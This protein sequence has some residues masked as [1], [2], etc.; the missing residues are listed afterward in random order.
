[1]FQQRR[2]RA[3]TISTRRCFRRTKLVFLRGGSFEDAKLDGSSSSSISSADDSNHHHDDGSTTGVEGTMVDS[4]KDST[5]VD[6]P[7]Q[8]SGLGS[9]AQQQQPLSP[10][11]ETSSSTTTESQVHPGP[12]EGDKASSSPVRP[13]TVMDSITSR[14]RPREVLNRAAEQAR[15]SWKRYVRPQGGRGED[16]DSESSSSSLHHS[17]PSTGNP[18]S[19]ALAA[20]ASLV[21]K[22]FSFLLQMSFWLHAAQDGGGPTLIGMYMAALL[23]ASC[24]FYLFLY[25]ISLGYAL[26]IGLPVSIA[27]VNYVQTT[28]KDQNVNLLQF[29]RQLGQFDLVGTSQQRTLVH[30]VLVILW[31][32][33]MF[34]FLVWREYWNWPALHKRI[35]QVNQRRQP[36]MTKT[37]QSAVATKPNGTQ[38]AP[39]SSQPTT[40]TSQQEQ[41]EQQLQYLSPPSLV[42]KILCW[43]IYSFF[44]LC[45]LSPCYFRMRYDLV[46][47]MTQPTTNTDLPIA[48]SIHQLAIPKAEY[49]A[50]SLQVL[51][52]LLECV[53]DWQKSTFKSHL[54]CR[55]E[56]CGSV[57]G[58]S[59]WKWST[60]PNYLGEALFWFG[61]FGCG[62]LSLVQQILP[63]VLPAENHLVQQQDLPL[64]QFL[65]QMGFMVL[66]FVFICKILQG[67][68]VSLDEKQEQK[69]GHLPAYVAFR[70]SHGLWGPTWRRRRRG[71]LQQ[72]DTLKERVELPLPSS[73]SSTMAKDNMVDQ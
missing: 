4:S 48:S 8:S 70:E 35:V 58:L 13:V 71:Q 57:R 20:L 18:L 67:A 50:L 72:N 10:I 19:Q 56:W 36:S 23:G 39:S 7:S 24:G 69:F 60:H 28:W 14:Q 54:N 43:L 31:S 45:M 32:L 26:G 49:L 73:S 38:S 66:G 63:F 41:H 29:R 37:G 1:M 42:I 55:F 46:A 34:V 16:L 59:L 21:S 62:M 25:F 11:Q 27:L 61:T 68:I 65:G 30:S 15:A 6:A 17:T 5:H 64:T 40:E 33:R 22:H 12:A 53:A 47:M 51:G 9:S 2:P 52:L 44:Y 3:K